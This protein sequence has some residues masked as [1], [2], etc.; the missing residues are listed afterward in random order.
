MTKDAVLVLECLFQT[1]WQFFTAWHIPGTGVTPAAFALF[2]IVAS[3]GLN[4]LFRLLGVAPAID[5]VDT[6]KTLKAERTKNIADKFPGLRNT[7]GHGKK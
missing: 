2:L 6:V 3:L 7:L 1:I 5:V 4:L